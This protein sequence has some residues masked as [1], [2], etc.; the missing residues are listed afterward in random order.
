M[1]LP[2]P[3]WRERWQRA[4]RAADALRGALAA[5]GVPRS[6]H[7]PIRGV[8]THQG[9]VLVDVGMLR[10]DAAAAVAAALSPGPP[11]NAPAHGHGEDRGGAAAPA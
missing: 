9:H 3:Q 6:A 2:M 11:H 10:E 4:D 5:L 7:G 1:P 8:V